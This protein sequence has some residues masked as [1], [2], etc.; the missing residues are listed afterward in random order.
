M[1][2]CLGIYI[3]DNIIKYAKVEKN[4]ENLKIESSNVVFYEKDNLKSTL[5]NVIRE[6]YSGNDLISINVSNE[7]YNY[8]DVFAELK[9]ADIE[10]SVELEFELLCGEKGYNK[11]SLERRSLSVDSKENKDK[12][13]VIYIATNREKLKNSIAEF[14]NAKV[15]A[16]TPI[17][18]SIS[19]LLKLT[20]KTNAI[21]V[22]IEKETKITTVLEGEVYNVDMLPYG[23]GNILNN[24]NIKENSLKKS[25]DCCKNTTIYTQ[26][27]QMLQV[28]EN[29]YLEDVMPELYKIVNEVKEIAGISLKPIDKIYVTGL[30]AAINN[31]DL[32]FQE[33]IPNAKCE[34]L[35]PFF[36]ENVNS[37]KKPI[38]DYIEVNSAIS[39]ALYGLGY[40]EQSLNF[41]GKKSSA[42]NSDVD[43]EKVSK[44]LFG[45][46]FLS[47]T[48]P[49]TGADKLFVRLLTCLVVAII[50][51]GVLST[52]I[53]EQIADKRD[54]IKK[55][56]E[57]VTTQI[58]KIASQ[59]TDINEGE[60]NYKTLIASI[61]AASNEDDASTN[62]IIIPK[63]AIPN[64]LNRIIWVIP[65]KVKITS[66]QNTNDN[67]IVIEAQANK[68]EQLG[69]F[70]AALDVNG[71]LENV[72]SSSGVRSGDVITITIEGDLP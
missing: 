58:A 48:N 25:Y 32:Y 55:S 38:K 28:E 8:F 53:L 39:L 63:D 22:N 35:K 68:H 4:K 3:E 59:V 20:P 15:T 43:F 33:Y 61:S 21:I 67:H 37:V 52:T 47:F 27:T 36:V 72:K 45:E 17:S 44:K 11:E 16:V 29:E 66:I 13:K 51:Y 30:A 56:D 71:I 54:E 12:T 65:T 18:T 49:F 57:E 31:V 1:P 62:E 46:N 24:I 5:E 70:K 6:T 23:M 9:P 19:N 7:L 14:G 2:K 26:D 69:F 60:N 50:S 42:L 40:G 10:K 41:K 34:L 64:L